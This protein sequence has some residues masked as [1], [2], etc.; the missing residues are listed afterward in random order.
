MVWPSET[1]RDFAFSIETNARISNC[2]NNVKMESRA[3]YCYLRDCLSLSLS[4]PVQ[5]FL[6]SNMAILFCDIKV[7]LSQ[8]L[9]PLQVSSLRH[10]MSHIS[11]Q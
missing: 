8:K 11:L 5:K 4:L 2:E 10:F 1:I 7:K 9:V 3:E 6:C